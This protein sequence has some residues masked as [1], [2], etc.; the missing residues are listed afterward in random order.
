MN[1]SGTPLRS[2]QPGGPIDEGFDLIAGLGLKV[3]E[4]AGVGNQTI[5]SLD[6]EIARDLI[7]QIRSDE[8][9]SS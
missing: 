9:E 6:E 4:R 5:E 8:L 3:L 7:A 1:M 2:E